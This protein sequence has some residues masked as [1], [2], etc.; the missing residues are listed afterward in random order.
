[1]QTLKLKKIKVEEKDRQL[2]NS[3]RL[4]A[5]FYTVSIRLPPIFKAHTKKGGGG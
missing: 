5:S 3:G 2:R 1:M 4:G